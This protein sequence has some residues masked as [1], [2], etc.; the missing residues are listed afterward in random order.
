MAN[1]QINIEKMQ[2]FDQS[3]AEGLLHYMVYREAPQNSP[4]ESSWSLVTLIFDLY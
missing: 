4:K 2:R 1:Y 3:N